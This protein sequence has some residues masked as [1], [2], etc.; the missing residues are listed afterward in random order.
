MRR[1]H[2]VLNGDRALTA[3]DYG[4]ALHIVRKEKE[5]RFGLAVTLAVAA[6]VAAVLLSGGAL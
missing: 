6:L 5:P 4:S 3:A 1:P 2:R